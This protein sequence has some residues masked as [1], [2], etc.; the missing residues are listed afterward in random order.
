MTTQTPPQVA[1]PLH[2]ALSRLYAEIQG[3]QP[4]MAGALRSTCQQIG[5]HDVWFGSTASSWA[6]DLNGYSAN[7]NSSIAAAVAVVA[8]ALACTPATCTPA[9]AKLENIFLEG[10]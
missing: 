5:G 1:S 3:D 10:Y 2:N 9:E 7:L 4:S 6:G 8:Q